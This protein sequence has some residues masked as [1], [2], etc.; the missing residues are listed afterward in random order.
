MTSCGWPAHCAAPA[1]R[2]QRG[3]RLPRGGRLQDGDVA[4]AGV[5]DGAATRAGHGPCLREGAEFHR[6]AAVGAVEPLHRLRAV[7]G[8][9]R[10][11]V[12][13][14]QL[15]E[16]DEAADEQ[17]RRAVAVVDGAERRVVAAEVGKQHVLLAPVLERQLALDA[18]VAGR[19]QRGD[20][21]HA[22][23][24]RVVHP[25]RDG[26][27]GGQRLLRLD[28]A[29]HGIFELRVRQPAARAVRVDECHSFHPPSSYS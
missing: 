24:P 17:D 5:D 7:G 6:R 27:R 28:Q 2:D 3:D 15:V 23:V 25:E 1:E 29:G 18:L 14:L 26:V 10:A 19:G 16:R 20:L 13:Q 8:L 12:P 11:D 9:E 22:V 21:Q 4:V